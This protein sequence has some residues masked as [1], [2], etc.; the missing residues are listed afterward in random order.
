MPNC[1]MALTLTVKEAAKLS[2]IG[3]N[4][5]YWQVKNNPKFP[6]FHIGKKT[7]IPRKPFEEWVLGLA[8][9]K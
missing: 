2:K 3:I 6:C 9:C 5:I 1:E 4:E 7:L 8:M